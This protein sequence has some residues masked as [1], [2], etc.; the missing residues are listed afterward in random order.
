MPGL[1]AEQHRDRRRQRVVQGPEDF[2]GR[3]STATGRTLETRRGVTR[4]PGP[5]ARPQ[6]PIKYD[7]AESVTT[8]HQGVP[9]WRM[10]E[11]L[12]GMA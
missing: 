1:V 12:A 2:A 8:V 3:L 7:P 6:L 10:G 9:Y 5:A 11:L 4:S